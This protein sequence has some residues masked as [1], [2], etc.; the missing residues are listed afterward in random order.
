MARLREASANAVHIIP[1][2]EVCGARTWSA[3]TLTGFV[4]QIEWSAVLI[5]ART[6]EALA[7][8]LFGTPV[9][10]CW[11]AWIGAQAQAIFVVPVLTNWAGTFFT[12]AG[13]RASVKVFMIVAFELSADAL[14]SVEAPD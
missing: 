11:A 10:A 9:V 6:V 8:T 14:A 1:D 5:R 3:I 12:L 2:L 13:A 7:L 4:V